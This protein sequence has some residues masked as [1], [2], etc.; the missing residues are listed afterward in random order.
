MKKIALIS[1]S[2][3]FAFM[4]NAQEDKSGT[5]KKLPKGDRLMIGIYQD[6]WQDTPD[7]IDI[8]GINQGFS[9]SSMMDYPINTSKFSLA[10]GLG[11]GVHNFYSD[12]QLGSYKD[13]IVFEALHD[14]ID[15]KVNKL[16][17]AYLDI[18]AEIRFRTKHEKKSKQFK[19]AV[20]GKVGFKMSSHTKYKGQDEV[21]DFKGNSVET[22]VKNKSY[23][24]EN[25]EK[26][27]YGATFRFGRGSWNLFGY[28]SL[29]KLF[30]DGKG[31][32][33]YPISVGLMI[34]PF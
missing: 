26:I 29:S 24:I 28:Y 27:R 6:L 23:D 10:V 21:D 34:T 19:I 3:L 2:L 4:V 5:A 20:G 12:A 7:S 8:R 32:E 11:I 14:T 31:S 33:M 9:F 15:Y 30:E 25:I 16:S 1:L 17:T 22:D 18:P 13:T